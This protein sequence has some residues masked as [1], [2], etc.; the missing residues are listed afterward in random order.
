MIYFQSFQRAI[1]YGNAFHCW[2]VSKHVLRAKAS[3]FMLQQVLAI[4]CASESQMM[5]SYAKVM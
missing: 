5:R 3:Y 2:K 1:P 4:L